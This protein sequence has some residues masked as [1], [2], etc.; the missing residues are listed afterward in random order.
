MKNGRDLL[1]FPHKSFFFSVF[2]SHS[3]FCLFLSHSMFFL[4]FFL[5]LPLFCCHS[6]AIFQYIN[7]KSSDQW[8]MRFDIYAYSLRYLTWFAF[9]VYGTHTIHLDQAIRFHVYDSVENKPLDV[10]LKC[11]VRIS[12]LVNKNSYSGFECLRAASVD[13]DLLQLCNTQYLRTRYSTYVHISSN[14]IYNYIEFQSDKCKLLLYVH[15]N[16]T[17]RHGSIEI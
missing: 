17:P 3:L 7:R 15:K 4:C 5:A 13:I 16:Q 2:F 9:V 12:V 14:C 11:S 6:N 10:S 8:I 1:F